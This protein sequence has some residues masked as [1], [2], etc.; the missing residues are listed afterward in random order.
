VKQAAERADDDN[1]TQYILPHYSDKE[2][3][4]VFSRLVD[5]GCWEYVG[6]VL[7]TDIN[8]T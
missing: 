5:G 7:Q 1:F 8:D 6:K 2:L 3:Q 4:P